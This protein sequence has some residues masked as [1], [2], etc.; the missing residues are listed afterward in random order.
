MTSA[1]AAL[2]F[3]SPRATARHITLSKPESS[4]CSPGPSMT[5]PTRM[6]AMPAGSTL[7]KSSTVPELGKRRRR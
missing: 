1:T 5:D 3:T 4:G 7:P 2:G 6:L